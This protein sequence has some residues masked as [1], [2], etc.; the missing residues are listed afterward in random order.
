MSTA[1]HSVHGG[2]VEAAV[3]WD[4]VSGVAWVRK[5]AAVQGAPT[6]PPTGYEYLN[7]ATGAIRC[8]QSATQ[9]QPGSCDIYTPAWSSQPQ[10]DRTGPRP[11]GAALARPLAR[12]ALITR[13]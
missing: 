6:H 7:M 11:R 9:E 12:A 1:A 8:A 3:G 10:L 5:P 4:P 2:P 13:R